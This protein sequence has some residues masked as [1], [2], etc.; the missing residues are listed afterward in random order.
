MIKLWIDD[1]CPIPTEYDYWC[2][3]VNE[4]KHQIKHLEEQERTKLFSATF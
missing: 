3:S 2:Q 1:L 4:T